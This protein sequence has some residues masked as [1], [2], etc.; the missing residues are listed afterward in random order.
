MAA[1]LPAFLVEAIFYL[2]SVFEE[3]RAWFSRIRSRRSQAGILLLSALLPYLIFSFLAGTFQR[4][5]FYLLAALCAV[6]AFWHAVLPRRF[7][8]DAGF[9]VIA[10]APV[11][12]RV[13][14]RIYESP[15]SHI[16][17]DILGHLMWIRVGVAALLV[18]R[19]WN[20]GEFSF[21]PRAREWRIGFLI[22]VVTLAPIVALAIGIHDVRFA[23]L[24]GEWWRVGEVA[25]GAFFGTLWVVALGEE[26]FFR[27][28]IERALLDG[29]DS[30]VLAVSVSAVLFGGAHLWF[31]QFPDWRQALVATVLGVACGI[32]YAKTGSVRA[33]MVMHAFMVATWRV[34]F[35]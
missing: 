6:L 35:K 9:L 3:T 16:R 17:I 13:F 22:Y 30:P 2:G 8:Y 31:H 34:F 19:E 11:I 26:L 20:P 25:V 21:W 23:P 7:A 15:D 18:L 27:G 33:P 10:A 28:V 14:R 4:N 12:L 5:A 1:A 24:Q 32:G 29:W